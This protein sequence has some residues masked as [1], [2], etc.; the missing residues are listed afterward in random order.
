M[1]RCVRV[2]CLVW[3]DPWPDH[4]AHL[5]GPCSDEIIAPSGEL[6][7]LDYWL[8][9][10]TTL[11][12]DAGVR[13]RTLFG[14]AVT[15]TERRAHR[16]G[17][18]RCVERPAADDTGTWCTEDEWRRLLRFTPRPDSVIQLA[19]LYDVD[20]AGTINLFP[21]GGV[22]FNS[23]VPRRHACES[24]HEKDAFVGLWGEP[25]TRSRSEGR[26]AT[27]LGGSVPTAIY[28]HL[29][30][31]RIASGTAGWG[32]RSVWREMY[33]VEREQPR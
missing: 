27:A 6:A 28:E 25:T 4:F 18:E 7:R 10:L 20:R 32:Y 31:G 15:E 21:A 2:P 29:T 26:I 22:A 13:R 8:G 1:V 16:T 9:R 24:F 12:G 33:P 17:M 14:M 23:G 30:S 3:Y 5:A 11:Y 19:H